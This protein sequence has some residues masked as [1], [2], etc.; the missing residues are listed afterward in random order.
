MTHKQNID[1]RKRI[2]QLTNDIAR[3]DNLYYNLDAPVVDDAT[4]D[5]LR[6]ELDELETEYPEEILPNSPRYRVGIAP[7]SEFQKVPHQVP[8]LSL[9]NVFSDQELDEFLKRTHRFLN[10]ETWIDFVAEPKID[11]LSASLIYENGVLVRVVTRGDGQTGEDITQNAKT[12][13]DIPLAIDEQNVEIRGEIYMEKDAFAA[14]NETRAQND[15]P[16]FANPR[17]AAAGSVRQLDPRIVAKRP[18]RFFAYYLM[19]NAQIDQWDNLKKLE[20]L[21]FKICTQIKLCQRLQDIQNYYQTM[22][23]MRSALSYDI[24]G[25]V[26]KINDTTL[27]QRLGTIGRTPRFAIAY[28]FP[29]QHGQTTLDDII[30]Q[31]GRNGTLTPVAVLKPINIGGVWI[32]RASLHNAD[33]IQRKNIHIG[34]L[35][36][37]KRAGDVIPQIVNAQRQTASRPFHFPATCPVCNTP[38]HRDQ[39]AI[40]CPNVHGCHAQIKEHIEHFVSRNAFNI[41]GLGKNNVAF[42]Y[43]NNYIKSIIDIFTLQQHKAR[44]EAEPGWGILSVE[45][46]LTAID[47]ARV[48]NLDRFIYALGIPMIGEVTAGL[49]ARH[50]GNINHF[51]HSDQDILDALE[52]GGVGPIAKQELSYF[53]EH[54]KPLL[55]ALL[56]HVI[57]TPHTIRTDLPL[58]GKTIVFTGTLSIS[59]SEAKMQAQKLG[60]MTGSTVTQKTDIVIVGKDPGSKYKKAIELGIPVMTEDEWKQLV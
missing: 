39:V 1:I 56:S 14:L 57:V 5:A 19:H 58:T 32:Q 53:L 12:I 23:K 8:M 3:H 37:V 28:K 34:D 45:N 46:L 24:D 41:D 52:I 25:V 29:P 43:D 31:V 47:R 2:Q 6:R 54:N 51:L 48:I 27:Q 33:E 20:Q 49:L 9:D 36:T 42:L 30:V 16:L 26:F 55:Q 50:F 21:G 15:E 22:M 11:G 59:R 7:V 35:V 17:N 10:D 13:H 4:Y 60:A 18:L 44:L 38:V 40:Y